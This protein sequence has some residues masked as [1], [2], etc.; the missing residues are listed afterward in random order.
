MVRA[1]RLRQDADQVRP[2]RLSGV[3]LP[4]S[5]DHWPTL[6]RRAPAGR[7]AGTVPSTEYGGSVMSESKLFKVLTDGK[8]CHGGTA[9]WKLPKGDKPG[10]WMPSI[11]G[12]L[13]SCEIGYHLTTDP[14]RWWIGGAT[15]YEAEY[16][17]ETVGDGSD[18]IA[19]RKARLLREVPWSDGQVFT[20]GQ[21]RVSRGV[22][23]ASGSAS[24][25]ASGSAS[26]E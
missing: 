26:V 4:V 20:E 3:P 15:L 11:A 5:R 14:A 1:A 23:R 12:S 6:A 16:D 7:R 17:G 2:A 25:E 21:H 22:S 24:V 18:K 13:K 9:T 19:A 8:S 10:A